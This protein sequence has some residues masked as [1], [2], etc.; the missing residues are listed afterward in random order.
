MLAYLM[1][2]F[3]LAILCSLWVLFQLWIRKHAPEVRPINL[4][5]GSCN[6]FECPR[7]RGTEQQD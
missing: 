4:C 6:S 2:V 5:C 3:G 7:D 1:A